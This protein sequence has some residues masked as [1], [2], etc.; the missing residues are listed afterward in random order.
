M[1][2]CTGLCASAGLTDA[3]VSDWAST[4]SDNSAYRTALRDKHCPGWTPQQFA[5]GGGNSP[6][7]CKISPY[8]QK[9][10]QSQNYWACH[11]TDATTYYDVNSD[12]T[13]GNPSARSC[14]CK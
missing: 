9:Y 13:D 3:P 1:E 14:P 6:T 7:Y 12:W 10:T 11:E 5:T 2:A 4:L 8:C